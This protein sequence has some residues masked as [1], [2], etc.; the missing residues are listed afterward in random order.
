M[1]GVIQGRSACMYTQPIQTSVAARM[2]LNTNPGDSYTVRIIA[3]TATSMMPIEKSAP[4]PMCR[5]SPTQRE[6]QGAAGRRHVCSPL[7]CAPS[8][9]QGRGTHPEVLGLSGQLLHVHAVDMLD[10][11]LAVHHPERPCGDAGFV[12][13]HEWRCTAGP[14][15][16]QTQGRR[17]VRRSARRSVDAL[18]M[19][20]IGMQG[21]TQAACSVYAAFGMSCT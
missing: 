14:D 8:N 19:C 7:P 1:Q 18:W 20:E 4:K 2:Q 9:L 17:R 6:C 11:R 13:H 5:T 12:Q 16:V 10:Q 15:P 21:G 3:N